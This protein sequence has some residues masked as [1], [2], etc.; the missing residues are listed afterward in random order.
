MD[1]CILV[2][3]SILNIFF[4]PIC[5]IT[6]RFFYFIYKKHKSSIFIIKSYYGNECKWCRT[7]EF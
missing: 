4:K 2:Y 7:N 3:W 5:F 1:R 6:Y